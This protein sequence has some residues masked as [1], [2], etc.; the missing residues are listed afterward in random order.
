MGTIEK[1]AS[2]ATERTMKAMKSMHTARLRSG[3]GTVV[4]SSSFTRSSRGVLNRTRSQVA[5][6]SSR[7]QRKYHDEVMA[8]RRE[9]ARKERAECI[10]ARSQAKVVNTAAVGSPAPSCLPPPAVFKAACNMSVTKAG[11]SW[12]KTLVLGFLAGALIAIG[13]LLCSVVSGSSPALASSNPGLASFVKGAIGL[14]AGL[15]MV[16]LTGGELFT[17]NVFFMSSGLLTKKI[18]TKAVAKNWFW[19]FSGNFLG[20]IFVAVLAFVAKT[21]ASE[22]LTASVT[23]AAVAKVSKKGNGK[24]SFFRH[25]SIDLSYSYQSF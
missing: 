13:A 16:I 23:K 11:Y 1:T 22:V 9:S 18:D 20:S 10:V 12:D 15:A 17:G 8:T 2:R 5:V 3:A 21:T 7:R 25:Q 6:T 24:H 14:P 4:M 19:S